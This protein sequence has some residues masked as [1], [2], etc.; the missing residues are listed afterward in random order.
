MRVLVTG[1][2]GFIG[3]R[4]VDVLHQEGHEVSVLSRRADSGFPGGVRVVHCDLTS[5]ECQLEQAL[6]GCQV[7]FHCAGEVRDVAV[8]KALH[9]GGTQRL[10][11]AAQRQAAQ[12]AQAMHWVQLSSVGAYGHPPQYVNRERVVTEE[13]PLQPQG[14]YEVTKTQA[15][16]LVVQAGRSGWLTYSIVRPSN[17]F[18]LEMPH[19]SLPRLGAMVRKGLFF[20]IG[21]PGA[22]ATWVHVDDV[23][24]VL[25]LCGSDPRAVGK[26]FNVSNDCLLEEMVEGIASA[27]NVRRPWLRLPEWPVRALVR[28]AAKVR[29]V[30]LTQEGINGLVRRTRYPYRK[31]EQE[32]GFTPRIS[33]PEAMGAVVLAKL[34]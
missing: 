33:V 6:E 23:V 9:V 15:D 32:L 8:M 20:F 10:L 18:G 16:E 17:V 28:V 34:N 25:R 27:L 11:A 31:L 22:V 7:V 12:R 19:P 30:P 13:T 5:V 2:S 21:R 26:T 3:R 14:E 29:Q 24:E 1:G 4:L